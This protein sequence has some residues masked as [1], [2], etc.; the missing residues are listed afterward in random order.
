[1]DLEPLLRKDEPLFGAGSVAKQ[2]CFRIDLDDR[3]AAGDRVAFADQIICPS[4]EMI[5][6]RFP[7]FCAMPDS[8]SGGGGGATGIGESIRGAASR[9][10]AAAGGGTGFG[11]LKRNG[12]R[13]DGRRVAAARALAQ[14]RRPA[15][16]SSSALFGADAERPLRV[17][18]GRAGT[19]DSATRQATSRG[20]R[21]RRT[22]AP[23][24]SF[25][26]SR[27][28][29]PSMRGSAAKPSSAH[30][31]SGPATNHV[32]IRR[33][34]RRLLRKHPRSFL[35]TINILSLSSLPA[36]RPPAFR[37]RR[38]PISRDGR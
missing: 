22:T 10:R 23:S 14:P 4:P 1:M 16:S 25:A 30:G 34:S 13:V 7:P 36:T 5:A 21:P 33:A 27:R 8:V 6:V 35:K 9:S 12:L 37:E 20:R 11:V 38:S 31:M 26:S 15:R 19:P 2:H 29:H 32:T 3:V 24:T 17:G 28:L 18:A